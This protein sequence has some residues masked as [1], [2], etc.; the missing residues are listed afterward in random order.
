MAAAASLAL[1]S[2]PTRFRSSLGA[3]SWL[4]RWS[5]LKPAREQ[6]PIGVVVNVTADESSFCASQ[7]QIVADIARDRSGESDRDAEPLYYADR[8]GSVGSSRGC[9]RGIWL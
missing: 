8:R 4:C 3:G 1:G 9:R 5:E 2:C 6:R 7:G